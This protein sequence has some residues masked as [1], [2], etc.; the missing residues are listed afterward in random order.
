[1]ASDGPVHIKAQG[2]SHAYGP[3][4]ILDG[5]DLTLSRGD[6]L[7]IMGPSG[8]G[9]STLLNC[10]AGLDRVQQGSLEVLG[11]SLHRMNET[12]RAELRRKSFGIV[13]QFFHLLPTLS[14]VENVELPLLM[15]GEKSSARRAKSRDIL[16]KVGMNHR[17]DAFP[18]TLSGGERQR[19]AIA[20]ALVTEPP[21]LFADEPTGNLDESTG[22]AV[23]GLLANLLSE[24]QTTFVMVTHSPRAAAICNRR[25]VLH[26]GQ[27]ESR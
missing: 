11:N 7:A 5:L 24:K 9:K 6:R 13:F 21:V 1:M 15:Q 3:T 17:L 10:L 18:E 22:D 16:E 20:R 8:A 14:A 25:M 23:L 19:V 12:E 27:L 26:H 4:T 2:L